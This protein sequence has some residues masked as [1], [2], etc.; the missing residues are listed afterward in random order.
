[1]AP[2]ARN[3]GPKRLTREDTGEELSTQAANK[4]VR[5]GSIPVRTVFVNRKGDRFVVLPDGDGV[6][7]LVREPKP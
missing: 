5:S 3:S 2:K 6:L 7:S 1:M 4:L